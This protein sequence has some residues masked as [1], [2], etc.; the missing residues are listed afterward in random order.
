MRRLA[1]LVLLLGAA[2]LI[3]RAACDVGHRGIPSKTPAPSPSDPAQL[4]PAEPPAPAPAAAYT[5]PAPAPASLPPQRSALVARPALIRGRVEVPGGL[6]DGHVRIAARFEFEG[7]ES[8]ARKQGS[9]DAARDGSFTLALPTG[10]LAARLFLDSAWLD[11]GDGV[12]AQAGA[13]GIVLRSRL[14]SVIEG[15]VLLP[16]GLVLHPEHASLEDVRLEWRPPADSHEW[17]P[18]VLFPEQD[19]SFECPLAPVGVEL[20]LVVESPFGPDRALHLAPL[21]PG[22]RRRLDVELEAGATV[23]G[24]VVDENGGGIEGATVV[25]HAGTPFVEESVGDRDSTRTETIE[26]GRFVFRG[27]SPR[28]WDLSVSADGWCPAQG[29]V[30]ASAP[31]EL[32]LVLRRGRTLEG[33]VTWDD[34][35][36]VRRV[37]LELDGPWCSI[38][39]PEPGRFEVLG[40]TAGPYRIDVHARTEVREGWATALGVVPGGAPLELV[41]THRSRHALEVL[42]LDEG[43]NPLRGARLSLGDSEAT[44]DERGSATLRTSAQGELS[45]RVRARGFLTFTGTVAGGPDAPEPVRVVL[46]R[47]VHLRGRVVTERGDPVA[48][49][50]VSGT[51][52][53]QV[54]TGPDG[55]FEWLAEETTAWLHATKAG[56]ADSARVEISGAPGELIEDL[57]LVLAPGCDLRGVLLD[58]FGNPC[59]DA[60]VYV[61]ASGEPS[62]HAPTDARGE[63]LVRDAPSGPVRVVS[64]PDTSGRRAS[65]GA[66]LVPGEMAAV[67][68]RLRPLDPVRLRGRVTRGGAPVA[69][70]GTLAGPS[71]RCGFATGHDG[72]FELE[73]P[74]PDRT[75]GWF[76]PDD[77]TGDDVPTFELVVSDAGREEVALE[78]EALERV[79]S[80]TILE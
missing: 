77:E 73:L 14:L 37:E 31:H 29:Q 80:D 34:G 6:P 35:T 66:V 64:D 3:S 54:L 8:E 24:R 56:W 60:L 46:A 25:I 28:P 38:S 19:G 69:G 30:D 72:R 71:L 67:E 21:V 16:E 63:F 74:Y 62:E 18:A 7:P 50:E 41:L 59:R 39:T 47:G 17:S 40:L 20:A 79:S 15:R 27:L 52:D 33:R 76:W 32:E 22:E 75:R 4:E 26:G 45:L 58:E 78:L 61:W 53:A 43:G 57:V 11:P 44:T 2:A 12:V 42:V 51:G 36:P 48:G 23:V 10:A 70:M 55:R 49:A 68:L 5:N 13:E 65:A 1:L 9:T